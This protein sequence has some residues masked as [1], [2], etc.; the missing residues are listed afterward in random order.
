MSRK[1]SSKINL[2]ALLLATALTACR[3]EPV[4]QVAVFDFSDEITIS[5]VRTPSHPT[6]AEYKR[7][8]CLYR[9]GKRRACWEMFPD[10]GGT[11]RI[12]VYRAKDGSIF[13]HDRV[14]SYAIN[15]PSE[16]F[17]EVEVAKA[18]GAYLGC[19]NQDTTGVW[20]FISVKDSPEVKILGD[21]SME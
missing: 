7:T 5:I 18:A 12:N 6:F 4:D 1:I 11:H 15:L 2:I 9:S 10:T 20:R 17:A 13:L 19:F 16:E 21:G 8:A 3:V 14:S